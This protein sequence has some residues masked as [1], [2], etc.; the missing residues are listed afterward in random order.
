MRRAAILAMLFASL[1]TAIPLEPE[2]Q[3]CVGNVDYCFKK[4]SSALGKQCCSGLYCCGIIGSNNV[5]QTK[6][7]CGE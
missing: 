1:A 2:K 6:N 4:A 5:C 3:Q 7:T